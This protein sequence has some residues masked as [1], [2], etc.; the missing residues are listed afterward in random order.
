MKP[1]FTFEI[2]P[3]IRGYD[4]YYLFIGRIEEIKG[5]EILLEAF[6]ECSVKSTYLE[7]QLSLYLYSSMRRSA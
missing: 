7:R 1:N 5:V 4:E 2:E 3:G 6:K